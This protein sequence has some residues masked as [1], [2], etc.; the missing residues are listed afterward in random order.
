MVNCAKLVIYVKAPI[1]M[2]GVFSPWLM[3][4]LPFYSYTEL[5]LHVQTFNV[6]KDDLIHNFK[7]HKKNG[8]SMLYRRHWSFEND[9]GTMK[10]IVGTSRVRDNSKLPDF[11]VGFKTLIHQLLQAINYLTALPLFKSLNLSPGSFDKIWTH[12]LF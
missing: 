3:W 12:Y 2:Y 5:H 4:T 1:C 11:M 9:F 10:N 6:N 7:A 8:Q